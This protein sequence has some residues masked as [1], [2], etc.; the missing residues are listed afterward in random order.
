MGT[1][2]AGLRG[3]AL[4]ALSAV[5]ALALGT[6]VLAPPAYASV[7]APKAPTRVTATPG[8]GSAV[9]KWSAPVN[10]GGNAVTGYVVRSSPGSKICKTTGAETCTI[11]GLSNGT[12]YSV[13]VRARNKDGLGATSARAT[14]KPGVPLAPKDARATAGNAEAKVIWT[15]PANNGSAIKKYTVKA[16][17]GSKTC[18]VRLT[19]CTMRGLRNG[20][21][22]RFTVTATN[23][24]GTGAASTLSKPVTPHLKATLIITASSGSQTF[25]GD[26][27]TISPEYSGFVNGDT[28]ADLTALPTCVSGTTARSSVGKYTSS[29]SGAVDP[30]YTI[31]YADGTTTVDAATLTITA[32][33]GIQIF[34][35][36]LPTISAQYS[37]FVNGDIPADLTTLPACVS[38]TTSSSPVEGSYS[39][40]C[41]GAVDPNYTIAYVDGT[42][43]VDPATLTITANDGVQT[44]DGL[45]PA[46]AAQYAGFVNGDTSTDL[47]TLPTC[48]AGTTSSS[49]VGTYT[50]SC[51]GA[52]DPNYTI[53]YV[54]GS[55]TVSDGGSTVT[56]TLT[57][58]A[59]GGIQIFGGLL[60]TISAQYSGFVNGDTP[61]DLATLPTCI[62]GTAGSSPVGTYTSSCSGAVDPNYTIVYVDGTT[63][64]NP[65]DLTISASNGSQTFGGLLATISAAY[66]G[67]VNGDTPA[68]LTTL[69]TCVPGTTSS[70]PVLGDY[71]S[72]CSGAA[73]PN[74]TINYVDG[75]TMVGPAPL[76][77]TASNG[78]Q[79]F[80]GLLPSISAT[81]SGFE[82]GDT[83]A[84]LTT[85]PTCLP[86]TTSSSPVL[87][88]YTSSCSGAVDPNYTIVYVDGTTTVNPA[89]LTISASNGSQTFGGLLATISAAYSGFVNGD[90]PASLTTL[91]TCVP[92]TT[93]SSPVL[94]DYLSSCSGAADPNYTID[95]TD[96]TTAVDPADLTITASN[97]TQTFGGLLATISAKYSGFV[98]GDSPS[99]LTTLPTCLPGTTSSSPVQGTYTSSC[100]GAVDPNYTIIYVNGTTS[101]DPATSHH[102]RNQRDSD[103]RRPGAHHLGQVLGLRGR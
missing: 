31:V 88:T 19:T 56:P 82:A 45:V 39:S 75:A 10:D 74:Y 14:V 15:A 70:S 6:L 32:S 52:V 94:G 68:S 9:V 17:P 51:S 65:A 72:S 13:T 43:T 103:I 41:S 8:N 49:P 59:S 53:D 50:S 101:V 25:G 36:L 34:G 40:S 2:R 20:T 5:S 96:G 55:T 44:L 64:V 37:G 71:L 7:G 18:T 86:G 92:G 58:T 29:C 28:P 11:R 1:Q 48:V 54:N 61:A 79:T 99:D 91:P 67:F 77:I 89:D 66:S 97:G 60:P 26:V 95:Y 35:G 21:A 87:G 24:R 84:D 80:G 73:D 76:T 78:S 30:K 46:I 57:I 4:C 38:G 93:S 3:R 100:T 22:Y 16:I 81:Y 47:T 12:T 23:A 27:P 69:P 33:G 98:N 83:P 63:T 102:H 42:T 90:T 62:S 85:L